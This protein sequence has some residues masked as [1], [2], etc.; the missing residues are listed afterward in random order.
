MK[1]TILMHYQK[2]HELEMDGLTVRVWKPRTMQRLPSYNMLAWIRFCA[3]EYHDSVEFGRRG[4][5]RMGNPDYGMWDAQ[6]VYH[7]DPRRKV[8]DIYVAAILVRPFSREAYD[9]YC[10]FHRDVDD[11]NQRL[12]LMWDSREHDRLFGYDTSYGAYKNMNEVEGILYST[13]DKKC[14][15]DDVSPDYY[16][17]SDDGDCDEDGDR[18][19]VKFKD[20]GKEITYE[21]TV[22]KEDALR[23]GG[24]ELMHDCA[25]VY[26]DF[27]KQHPEITEMH[28]YSDDRVSV[29]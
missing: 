3:S 26:T 23:D 11:V 20:T 7:A 16:G 6:T 2:V 27:R 24:T 4:I 25:K 14:D 8:L 28:F 18:V 13:V 17:L 1:D 15:V 29:E 19:C 10:R 12:M 9:L 5:W 21:A 22:S